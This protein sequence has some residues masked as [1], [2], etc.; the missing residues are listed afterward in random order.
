MFLSLG[1]PNLYI[2]DTNVIKSVPFLGLFFGPLI[3]KLLLVSAALELLFK[4]LLLLFELLESFLRLV[5][6]V[7]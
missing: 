5:Y 4:L 3:Q 2:I 7:D 6:A 1:S